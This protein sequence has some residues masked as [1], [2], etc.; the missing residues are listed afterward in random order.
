VVFFLRHMERE[1]PARDVVASTPAY[2]PPVSASTRTG[3]R[4]VALRLAS[5]G[6]LVGMTVA[7]GVALVSAWGDA[8]VEVGFKPPAAAAP[9]PVAQQV[10]IDR[11]SRSVSLVRGDVVVWRAK[12]PIDCVSGHRWR[13]FADR[14][15]LVER[16]CVRLG[17]GAVVALSGRVPEGAALRLR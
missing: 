6:L 17:S 13:S 8:P 5:A 12:G 10:V 15:A 14:I 16:A 11:S 4:R 1:S 9:A 7:A 2:R 3:G